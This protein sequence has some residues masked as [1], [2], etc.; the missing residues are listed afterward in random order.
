MHEFIR[1]VDADEAHRQIHLNIDNIV[2][3]ISD[4]SGGSMIELV[5]GKSVRVTD[6]PEDILAD[7]H[8]R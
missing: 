8:S 7:I 1:L 3:I 2:A 6:K 5:N 4:P